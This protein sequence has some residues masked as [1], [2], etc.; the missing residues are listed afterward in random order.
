MWFPHGGGPPEDP[1]D[2]ADMLRR[3]RQDPQRGTMAGNHGRDQRHVA[4]RRWGVRESD[5]E[6]EDGRLRA[7]EGRGKGS[8]LH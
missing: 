7:Q 1:V 8:K 2:E 5:E 3:P 4:D 6:T